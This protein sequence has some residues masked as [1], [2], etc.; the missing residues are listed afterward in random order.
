MRSRSL[1]IADPRHNL[2]Q[3]DCHRLAPGNG[4]GGLLLNLVLQRVDRC[5]T[6]DHLLG[7]TDVTG[8][9]CRG[10]VIKCQLGVTCHFADQ[11]IQLFELSVVGDN[12]A[13]SG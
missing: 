8:K 9:Q 1:A 13:P 11:C 3:I 12:G 5:I 2:A 7:E 10:R 6:G 4:G